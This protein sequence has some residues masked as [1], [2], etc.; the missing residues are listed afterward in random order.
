VLSAFDAA[1]ASLVTGRR[2]SSTVAPQALL[3]LNH[4][5]VH[6]NATAAAERLLLASAALTSGQRIERAYRLALGRQPTAEE[7]AVLLR[8]VDQT[9]ANDKNT[10]GD[11]KSVAAWRAVFLSLFASVDFRFVD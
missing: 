3:M 11:A 4:P 7:A 9:V 8:F 10:I 2:D 6:D 1:N 5:F